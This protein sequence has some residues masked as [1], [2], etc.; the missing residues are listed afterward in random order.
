M[1]PH[2][3]ATGLATDGFCL[4]Q[5]AIDKQAVS[6][7]LAEL[8]ILSNADGGVR[9][10]SPNARGLLERCPAVR[11]I[12][13]GKSI[14]QIVDPVLGPEAFAVR[15][16]LFDKVPDANWQVGW[17]QDVIIPVARKV[18]TPGFGPWSVKQGVPHV[19]PPADV[20]AGML[21]LRIHLDDCPSSNGP[22]EVLPGTHRLGIVKEEHVR[23]VAANRSPTMCTASAGDVLVMRPL[24][25]HRSGHTT[26]NGH[27]RVVHLEFAAKD[28]PGGVEWWGG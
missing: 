2:V 25:F 22:L 19:R 15:G 10:G 14:Q 18:E 26:T 13:N 23:E 7:L 28:L 3:D 1:R 5:H 16:L 6:E 9:S 12:A 11:R 17:H 4:V 20:L 27:R 8:A 24:I 21:T